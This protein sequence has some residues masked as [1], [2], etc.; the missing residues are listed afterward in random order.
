MLYLFGVLFFQW[1]GHVFGCHHS[2][3]KTRTTLANCTLCQLVSGFAKRIVF[4][5]R[6]LSLGAR[7]ADFSCVSGCN[8][9]QGLVVFLG[10]FMVAMC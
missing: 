9:A 8:Q 3:R 7:L 5:S 4:V 10:V 2:L 6:E 1:D